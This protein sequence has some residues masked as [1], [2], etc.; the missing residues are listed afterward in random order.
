M[1]LKPVTFFQQ[2][3]KPARGGKTF[4]GQGRMG[5]P[6]ARGPNSIFKPRGGAPGFRGGM[7]GGRGFAPRGRGAY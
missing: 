7:R 4:G 1:H 3:A 2:R 5:P 6:I